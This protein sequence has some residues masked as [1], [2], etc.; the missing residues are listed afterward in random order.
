[1]R[2]FC[3]V[4]SWMWIVAAGIAANFARYDM[5]TYCVASGI[6]WML[7]GRTPEGAHE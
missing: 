4:M 5:G 1:M 6:F 3:T 7:Q 2:R